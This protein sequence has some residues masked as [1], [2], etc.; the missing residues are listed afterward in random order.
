[1]YQYDEYIFIAERFPT[2]YFT[3]IGI[4][5][6]NCVDLYGRTIYEYI[7]DREKDKIHCK[8]PWRV[9]DAIKCTCDDAGIK[10]RMITK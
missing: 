4:A 10:V 7:I 3:M 5:V 9:A 6:N 2:D 8:I 1:M